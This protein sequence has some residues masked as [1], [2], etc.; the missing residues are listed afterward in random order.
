M[1]TSGTA[2]DWA[3]PADAA[4]VDGGGA[5]AAAGA[6]DADGGPP[7]APVTKTATWTVT[8][9][10]SGH[11]SA[12][13]RADDVGTGADSKTIPTRRPLSVRPAPLTDGAASALRCPSLSETCCCL[14]GCCCFGRARNSACG[15]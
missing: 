6:G 2:G 1:E 7:S 3:R 14:G 4:A 8:A 5:A 11:W 15:E 13:A 12:R 10:A 9:T